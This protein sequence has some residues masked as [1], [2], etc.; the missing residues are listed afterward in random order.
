MSLRWLN[1]KLWPWTSEAM[2]TLTLQMIQI[3]LLKPL[4]GMHTIMVYTV[5]QFMWI[6]SVSGILL[7]YCRWI[8]YFMIH[9][10]VYSVIDH[11]HSKF[12]C[13]C[14][15]SVFI[16]HFWRRVFHLES[17]SN[18][19]SIIHLKLRLSYFFSCWLC[20]LYLLQNIWLILFLSKFISHLGVVQMSEL[21]FLCATS[22]FA[23]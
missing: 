8:S 23:P 3:S 19:V 15:H 1:V 2:G 22:S 9:H 18:S 7:H 10:C 17:L 14:I 5:V 13:V 20:H 6:A 11:S 4:L 21:Y 16:S 12:I